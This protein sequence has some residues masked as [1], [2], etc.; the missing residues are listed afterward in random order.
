VQQSNLDRYKKD[1]SRLISTGNQLALS[2]M[3]ESHDKAK[4]MQALVSAH[5]EAQGKEIFARLPPFTFNYQPWYSEALSLIKYVLPDRLDDFVRHYEK[6][7]GRRAL[8]AES[9]RIEDALQGISRVDA[10]NKP[11]VGPYAAIP[12]VQQQVSMVSAAA[13]RFESS[14]FDIR[15]LAQAD[16]FD[17]ELD[18]A[19]ELLKNGFLR[20]AGAIAGV[21]VEGHL[22][23][24]CDKHSIKVA[25]KNPGI[26]DFNQALKD[27][28][29]IET[30]QWRSIQ[31]LGDLRNLCDHDKKKDPTKEQ[32]GDLID[33]VAKTIKTLF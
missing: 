15:Q 7:K 17:S 2:L 4:A 1:I 21:V 24:V 27:A 30:P 31:H 16:V 23:E 18:A 26:N 9:Y 11:V 32:V 10:F 22:R 12:H 3:A 29:V 8:D 6:P 28:E 13:A 20:A 25:K 14:L 5:G 19:R 33:G